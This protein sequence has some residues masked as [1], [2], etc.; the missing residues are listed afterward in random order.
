MTPV[1]LISWLVATSSKARR[2]WLPRSNKS[3]RSTSRSP[4]HI[5][6]Q[7]LR[8]ELRPG[9]EIPSERRICGRVAGSLERRRRG[10]RP[11]C[12]PRRSSRRARVGPFV[13]DDDAGA[14]RTRPLRRAAP[15]ARSTPRESG[16]RSRPRARSRRPSPSPWPW[17][18]RSERGQSAASASFTRWPA[19]RDLELVVFRVA[20]STSAALA[21][22][23]AHPRGDDRLHRGRDWSPRARRTRSGQRPARDDEEAAAL[24][25]GDGPAAVLVVHHTA[26][27]AAGEP[28]EFAEAVLSVPTAGASK[29]STRFA[30]DGGVTPWS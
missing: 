17:A 5:R 18:S 19:P 8:G 29:T 16:A 15:P 21:E 27:D 23:L 7:I 30:A 13:R 4:Y 10:T 3:C 22:A 6:D 9:D 20:G 24:A 12:A 25:L 28:I 14:S 11:L 26:F 2:A 1:A